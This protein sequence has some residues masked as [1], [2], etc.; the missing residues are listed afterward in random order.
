[1][2]VRRREEERKK[3]RKKE[4]KDSLLGLA[5]LRMGAT[6]SGSQTLTNGYRKR[7]QL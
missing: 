3:E 2:G 7:A 6:C 1:M 4:I 5:D